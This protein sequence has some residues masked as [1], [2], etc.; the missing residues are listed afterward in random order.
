MNNEIPKSQLI[1]NPL[2]QL[3]N[4][5][6]LAY[7]YFVAYAVLGPDRSLSEVVR[8][9]DKPVTYKNQLNRWSSQHHWTE[10][11]NQY[12]RLNIQKIVLAQ[13]DVAN[14]Y[15]ARLLSKDDSVADQ[16]IYLATTPG[17][18]PDIQLRAI[19]EFQRVLG[20][21]V[22]SEENIEPSSCDS[23]YVETL[24]QINNKYR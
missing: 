7:R 21:A 1:D 8:L 22:E 4:E 6:D 23:N 19:Q 5:T 10:R 14:Q 11:V 16:L 13:A 20:I 17:V 18:R 12:D 2:V 9:Y 15:K 24:R 3:E